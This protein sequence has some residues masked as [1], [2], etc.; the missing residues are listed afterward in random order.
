MKRNCSLFCLSLML[1]FVLAISSLFTG[2]AVAETFTNS[3]GM[4]FVKIP[5]GTFMMGSRESTESVAKNPAYSDKLSKPDRFKDEHPL[6]RVTITNPF[7]MQ[8]TEV[9]VV[10]F[11]TFTRSTGYETD[12]ERKG[13]GRVHDWD[14]GKWVDKKGVSWRNP[15]F[16]QG[17]NHPALF[18][19]WNDAGAFMDWLNEKEHTAKYRLP[20]EAQWEYACRAC[21]VTPFYWGNRPS[22]DHA[23]FADSTYS[24]KFPSDEYVNRGFND[25]YAYTAP[26]GSFRLN[27][28]GLYDMSGNVWEWCQDWYGAYPD[29]HVIDPEGLSSGKYRV[30]RGGSWY[31][32]ARFCRSAVRSRRNP[33]YRGYNLGFRVVRAN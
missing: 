20:S 14:K 8:T 10:M 29:G 30:L 11:R 27:K 7:Y 32:N 16:P 22:G 18:V 33:G 13:T 4:K 1:F 24:G 15:G 26:V 28:W 6:H 5:A 3:I 25:G 12:A 2:D 23:N 19:S 21:S 9:T 31:D 17:N